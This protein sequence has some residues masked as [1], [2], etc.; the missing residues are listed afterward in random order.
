[1][2]TET[3]KLFNQH[4][5]TALGASLSGLGLP[6]T[7]LANHIYQLDSM[8]LPRHAWMSAHNTLGILFLFFVIWH[9]VLNR[10]TLAK[11]V[12]GFTA[13]RG[14]A[15]REAICATVIVVFFVS[16]F[17]GHAFHIQG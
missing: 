16:F 11:Y 12:R 5:F 13:G 17:V 6:F 4:A 2:K 7:G 9:I 14:F 15:S 3:A 10:R 1:M 8:T